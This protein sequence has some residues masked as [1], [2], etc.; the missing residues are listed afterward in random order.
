MAEAKSLMRAISAE[1]VNNYSNNPA[2]VRAIDFEMVVTEESNNNKAPPKLLFDLNKP[3]PPDS[4]NDDNEP[5][6][7][8]DEAEPEI[9]V[10]EIPKGEVEEG[11]S[12]WANKRKKIKKWLSATS[13]I[14]KKKKN[15]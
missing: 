11:S 10:S 4:S 9:R 6:L 5:V 1:S 13:K 12:L 3:P 2:S 14:F 7:I 15:E 8:P